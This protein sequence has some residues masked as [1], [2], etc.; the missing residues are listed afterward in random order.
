MGYVEAKP[1]FERSSKIDFF[2][3]VPQL[4]VVE[5]PAAV[6]AAIELALLVNRVAHQ[7]ERRRASAL[8]TDDGALLDIRFDTFCH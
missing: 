2:Y 7:V 3:F 1:I 8:G 6:L 4:F 5:R